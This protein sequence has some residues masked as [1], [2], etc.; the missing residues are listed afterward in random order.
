MLIGDPCWSVVF[1]GS[2]LWIVGMAVFIF[3][4]LIAA[5]IRRNFEAGLLLIPLVLSSLGS[6]EP[7]M[8]AGMSD[9]DRARLSLAA[10]IQAGPV[11]IHFAS[12][13]DFAGCW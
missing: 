9:C 11:P 1:L 8:T 10:D 5:T 13:A 2:I 12:I 4:T 7:I 6:C 3:I